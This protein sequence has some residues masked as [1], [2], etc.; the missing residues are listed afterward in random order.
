VSSEQKGSASVKAFAYLLVIRAGN[1]KPG[2]EQAAIRLDS[3]GDV[4]DIGWGGRL[5]IALQTG[6]ISYAC[7]KG[8]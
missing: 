6:P 7:G 5:L 8:F 1:L 4:P 3:F 2:E